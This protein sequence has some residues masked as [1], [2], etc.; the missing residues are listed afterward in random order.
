MFSTIPYT[1]LEMSDTFF[2][3]EFNKLNNKIP[4]FFKNVIDS[5]KNLELHFINVKLHGV[6]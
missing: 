1:I 4:C 2:K 6:K 3:P 5:G